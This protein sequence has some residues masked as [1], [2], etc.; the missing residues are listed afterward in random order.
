M[1]AFLYFSI[2]MCV[3]GLATFFANPVMHLSRKVL[4]ASAEGDG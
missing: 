4:A 3:R 1:G 2:W